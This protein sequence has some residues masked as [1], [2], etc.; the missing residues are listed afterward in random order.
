MRA[1]NQA[2]P[3]LEKLLQGHDPN[4]RVIDNAVKLHKTPSSGPPIPHTPTRSTPA[5]DVPASLPT[6]TT[7]TS[8]AP[9]LDPSAVVASTTDGPKPEDTDVVLPITADMPK[10]PFIEDDAKSGIYPYNA[11]LHPFSHLKR[12]P[13]VNPSLFATRLQRLLIPSIMPTG[14]DPN[15]II[16]ERNRFVDARIEWRIRELENMS[17]MMGEGGLDNS[18]DDPSDDKAMKVDPSTTQTDPSLPIP[19]TEQQQQKVEEKEN[20]DLSAL[21]KPKV[22]LSFPGADTHG[23][24]RAL[25]E[26]KSLRVLDK[27]RAMRAMVAERL[28]HGSLLPL[29]RADFR[30][31]RKPTLRDTRMTEQAERKQRVDRERRAKQKHVEQLSIICRHGEEVLTANRNAQARV[32]RLGKNVLSFHA[33][34][35]REEQKRIERLAKERLKVIVSATC[36]TKIL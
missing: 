29:N 23:K 24:L 13:A 5:P 26:L 1:P 8:S 31:V 3:E 32:L 36:R 15:Q 6:S 19:P 16:A 7:A 30:R 27:Q 34:T 17:A 25:I 4:A 21:I 2:V 14:L 28:T 12:D 9:H 10:G 11:Y 22:S 33:H 35:E 18:L 20:T